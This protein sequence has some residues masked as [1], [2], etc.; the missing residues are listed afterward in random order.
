MSATV[1]SRPFLF[2]I[3][4]P[5]TAGSSFL[6][7]LMRQ[8]GDRLYGVYSDIH[9]E[10]P[11]SR[12]Q[13]TEFVTDYGGAYDCLASHRLSA[14][15]PGQ[16]GDRRCLGVSFVRD[17][18]DLFV[19]HYYY[20]RFHSAGFETARELKLAD[21]FEYAVEEGNHPHYGNWQS[22]VL[23]GRNGDAEMIDFDGVK[24]RMECDELYVFPTAGFDSSY[25]LLE[26]LHPEMFGGAWYKRKNVSQKDQEVP[27]GLRE[28]FAPYSREDRHLLELAQAQTDR[29][30][31]KVFPGESECAE[32][33]AAFRKR[34]RWKG[35]LD[36]PRAG[37]RRLLRKMLEIT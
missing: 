33:I 14:N 7:L 21:Y 19:S 11:F 31:A 17:P 8:Y 15:F 26:R 25:V 20:H 34:N 4:I 32:A 3:H 24:Q 29:L 9:D 36:L 28:R 6:D 2:F 22:G 18:F 12:R 1:S 35:R 10:A 37:F 30:M 23:R 16:V 13:L 5:K 27:E